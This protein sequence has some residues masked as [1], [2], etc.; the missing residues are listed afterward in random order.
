[1]SCRGFI[2]VIGVA[3]A[4]L[5]GCESPESAKVE[6]DTY[7]PQPDQG[8][9]TANL[10]KPRRPR[11]ELMPT[12][13]VVA[14]GSESHPDEISLVF[15]GDILLGHAMTSH[16]ARHGYHWPFKA[17]APLLQQA[18]LTVANHEG[19]LLVR[20]DNP[21][22]RGQRAAPESV[23]GLLWAGIDAVS[24]ANNHLRDY[25]D[26]GI[27]E[28]IR[29]LEQAGIASFG[30]GE[31]AGRARAPWIFETRGF[32]IAV[33]GGISTSMLVR[34]P[35]SQVLERF[36]HANSRVEMGTWLYTPETLA[37]DVKAAKQTADLVV[38]SLHMGVIHY[39]P[40]YRDQVQ[41]AT[42][43]AKAGADLVVG[44]QAHFWQP[45]ALIQETA[46]VYGLGNYAFGFLDR[47]ADESLIA[48][49]V[50]SRSTRRITR[51]ELFPV[52]TNNRDPRIAFQSKLMAGDSARV[53]LE[54]LRTWSREV[55]STELEIKADRA[56][57][58]VPGKGT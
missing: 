47:L 50:V 45:A 9:G 28:T 30:V 31:D 56:V 7:E 55:C 12:S 52:A 40:P 38:V 43:A 39:R 54:D 37:A 10:H 15:V 35:R 1:M 32:R 23:T 18:D 19:S 34:R 4:L 36:T 41:L 11:L 2:L 25:G 46:V 13:R 44:H 57:L 3:L 42:A 14:I 48:R 20:T 49:A 5:V 8:Y 24:L 53:V 27:R 17:T 58:H 29:H 16:L 6:A 26:R 22:D 21:R 51:V 33:I